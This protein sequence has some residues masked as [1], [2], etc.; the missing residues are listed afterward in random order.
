MIAFGKLD[1][2]L[3]TPVG[4]LL[5]CLFLSGCQQ[6]ST[7]TS[8]SSSSPRGMQSR[9]LKPNMDK[10][11][12][13]EK[14][15]NTA[16]AGDRGAMKSF[17]SRSYNAKD[18]SGLKNYSGVKNYKTAEFSQ[19]GKQSRFGSS[20]SR[21]QTQDSRMGS[22]AFATKDS[23]FGGMTARQDGKTFRDGNS[24]FQTSEFQ[25]ARKSLDDNKQVYI[26]AGARD[27]SKNANAYSEG[28]VKR[29]LGR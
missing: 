1:W 20:T 25:P 14:E 28:D 6:S 16:S 4:V 13:F 10:S 3:P 18:V 9:L 27:P 7:S 22:Q 29:M 19:A 15:F 24:V 2:T 17:G 26:E 8:S 21:Y 5:A 12:P 11:S 23:K